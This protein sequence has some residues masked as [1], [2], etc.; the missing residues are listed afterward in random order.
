MSPDPNATNLG[1]A[2]YN[3]D[4]CCTYT[5]F[6]QRFHLLLSLIQMNQVGCRL[7]QHF[8]LSQLG[9]WNTPT[10]MGLQL[11]NNVLVKGNIDCGAL[12]MRSL[13]LDPSNIRIDQDMYMR[14]NEKPPTVLLDQQSLRIDP[15]AAQH[16]GVDSTWPFPRADTYDNVLPVPQQ[17][18][19]QYRHDDVARVVDMNWQTIPSERMMRR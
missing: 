8:H 13:L 9:E 12:Q 16:A 19:Y 15:Q 4:P 10:M 2:S 14:S 1:I 7:W 18:L 3:F 11:H 6:H 5:V 17:C